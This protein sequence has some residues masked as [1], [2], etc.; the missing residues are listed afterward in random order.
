MY[1]DLKD[2][3]AD[4]LEEEDSGNYGY[5][6]RPRETKSKPSGLSKPRKLMITYDVPSNSILVSNASPS[7]TLEIKQLIEEF[8]QPPRTDSVEIR[9]TEAIKIRYSK[10]SVIANAV[11]EVYRDLLSAKDKE[12]ERGGDQRQQGREQQRATTVI[13]YGPQSGSGSGDSNRSSIK[14]GFEGALSIGVDEISNMLLISANKVIFEDVKRM[15]K[16][17]DEEAAPDTTVQV[18]RVTGAVTAANLQKVLNQAMSKPWPGGRPE[19][20]AAQSGDGGRRDGDERGRDRDRRG[21][22][23]RDGNR[24]GNGDGGGGGRRSSNNNND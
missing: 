13:N 3:F 15:V 6:Y 2:Y 4:D 9:Q 22:R 17:L 10:A 5:W 1:W 19:Q 14:A 11:K 16:E 12:F 18:H 21:R 23:D 8:D 7:Q 20:A 24:D